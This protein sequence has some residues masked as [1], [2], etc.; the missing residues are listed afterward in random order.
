MENDFKIN[1]EKKRFE[2]TVEGKTALIN[3][4]M[5][6]DV[7]Q[8][9]H[10]EVPAEHEGQ[11]VGKDLVQQSLTYI[12]DQNKK[13]TPMCSFVAAYVKRHPEWQEIVA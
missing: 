6:G 4:M 1:E 2:L 9:V 7:Y 12:K 5:S 3:Y 8:L 10:T 11:G 13:M